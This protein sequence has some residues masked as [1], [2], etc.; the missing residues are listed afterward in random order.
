MIV[1]VVVFPFLKSI[2]FFQ[3]SLF[4]DSFSDVTDKDTVRDIMG[5]QEIFKDWK[6]LF[7]GVKICWMVWTERWHP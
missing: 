7:L 2:C 4:E 3:S 6:L 1:L 5:T